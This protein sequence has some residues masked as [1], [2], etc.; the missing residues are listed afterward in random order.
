MRLAAIGTI[1]VAL[2]AMLPACAPV[3]PDDAAQRAVVGGALGATLGAGIGATFA[4]NPLVGA[5]YGAKGGAELG[6]AVGVATATET[7]TYE[8]IVLPAEAAVPGFY[9]NWPP[10]YHRPPNNPETK[11]PHDG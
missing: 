7:P 9:D 4:I 2:A 3:D 8:P 10:G 6:A 11:S 1:A 5:A